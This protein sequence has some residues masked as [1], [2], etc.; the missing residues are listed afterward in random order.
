M[1]EESPSMPKVQFIHGEFPN[2]DLDVSKVIRRL[3]DH[4]FRL[5]DKRR[6][7]IEPHSQP[8]ADVLFDHKVIRDD[9]PKAV[10]IRISRWAHKINRNHRKNTQIA[11]LPDRDREFLE[12][13]RS[14]IDLSDLASEHQADEIAAELHAEFPW[15]G[16]ATECV[17][18]GLRQSFR[19]G[20]K[21]ACISPMLLDGP[22]G[23]GKSAWARRLAHLLETP[24]LRLDATTDNASFGLVGSQRAWANGAPGRLLNLMLT[25]QVA[26]PVVI[27]DEVEKSGVPT[28]DKGRAFS[29]PD[30]LLPLL[31]SMTSSHWSCPYFQVEFDMRWVNWVLTSNSHSRLP[32]PLLSRLRTIHVPALSADHMLQFVGREAV[33]RDLGQPAQDGVSSA[34]RWAFSAGHSPNLRTAI[35]LLEYAENMQN[36]PLLH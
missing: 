6:L 7:S 12:A 5:Q 15:L 31:E 35:R 30:A 17:W 16:E 18:K 1:P 25:K 29:L 9:L 36:R 26:N 24:V 23:I 33:R 32:A 20:R 28:S 27:I 11:R 4:W 22:P 2:P 21:G 14:G 19:E 3:S 8:E 34:I 13:C 10:Q